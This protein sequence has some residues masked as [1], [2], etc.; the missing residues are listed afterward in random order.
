MELGSD[1]KQGSRLKIAINAFMIII[2][3]Y[4]ISVQR[5]DR[6]ETSAFD[7]IMIDTLAPMQRSITVLQKSVSDFINHYLLNVSSSKENALLKNKIDDLNNSLFLV[8][9]VE[10]ENQR[11]KSLLQFGEFPRRKKILSRIVSWDSVNEHKV[12][13]IDKGKK[14]GV[15]IQSPVVTASG[16]VGYVFRLTENFSD[17]QTLLDE[18]SRV[19]AIVGRTRTHGI[20]EGSGGKLCKVKYISRTEPLILGDFLLTSGLGNIYP[21][22]IKVGEIVHVEREGN[23]IT[24]TIEIRPSVDFS[25]LEEVVVLVNTNNDFIDEW[26]ALDRIEE[27]RK[28]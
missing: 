9:E 10:N 7:R 28:E 24:Q 8:K 18:N 1:G 5:L 12:I 16:L 11:L 6:L 23:N 19:D 27:E 14:Q 22:G 25:E 15:E 4:G 21:K 13:R 2:S 3:L 26:K 17:V 20:V